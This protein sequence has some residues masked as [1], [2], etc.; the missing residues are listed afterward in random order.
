MIKLYDRDKIKDVRSNLKSIG[1]RL[2]S[3]TFLYSQNIDSFL[4]GV[5]ATGDLIID[6]YYSNVEAELLVVGEEICKIKKITT[7]SVNRLTQIEV[8]RGY[9]GTPVTNLLQGALVSSVI[10]VTL[11]VTRCE[12]NEIMDY[13]SN[14]FLVAYGTGT[15]VLNHKLSDWSRISK[16]KKY[17]W[18][19]YKSKVFFFEGYEDQV[20]LT[21]TGFVKRYNSS[22]TTSGLGESV[23]FNL[24]DK[25]GSY[26]DK[27]LKRIDPM[28]NVTVDEAL[29]KIFEIPMEKIYYRHID[30]DKYPIIPVIIPNTY[31]QYSEIVQ[32]FSTNGIRFYF[33]PQGH[34]IIFS[35]VV[36]NTNLTANSYLDDVIHL[37]DIG[38]TSDN[39]LIYNYFDVTYGEK[40]PLFGLDHGVNYKYKVNG[41]VGTILQ[42]N[43]NGDYYVKEIT[44]ND[45]TIPPRIPNLKD[46]VLMIKDNITGLEF[47]CKLVDVNASG[48][49]II[50]MALFVQRGLLEFGRGQWLESLGFLNDRTFTLYYSQEVLPIVS[51]LSNSEDTTA[52]VTS[53]SNTIPIVPQIVDSDNTTELFNLNKIYELNFGSGVPLKNLEYTGDFVG[54]NNLKGEWIGGSDL[55]YCR[56]WEQSQKGLDIFVT[57]TRSDNRDLTKYQPYYTHQDNSGFKL[58]VYESLKDNNIKA[59][60]FNTVRDKIKIDDIDKVSFETS[61]IVAYSWIKPKLGL[62]PNDVLFAYKLLDGATAQEKAK[63]KEAQSANIKIRIASMT[64]TQGQQMLACNNL[65]FPHIEYGILRLEDIVYIQEMYIRLDPIVQSSEQI[66][67]EN[68]SSVELYDGKK[69]FSLVN[70][71]FDKD[72]T[73]KLISFVNSG[74]SGLDKESMKYIV[75]AQ[76]IQNLELE[77]YDLVT[78]R[79]DTVTDIDQSMLW[80]VVGKTISWQAGRTIKYNLLNIYTREIEYIDVAISEVQDFNPDEEPTYMWDGVEADKENVEELESS[81]N[82]LD[83]RWGTL[84]G[85]LIEPS[86]FSFK[87]ISGFPAL[88]IQPSGSNYQAYLDEFFLELFKNKIIVKI[89]SEFL[90]CSGS[91]AT[92]NGE[93][94]YILQIIDRSLGQSKQESSFL[95]RTA[96]VYIISEG[97]SKDFGLYSSSIYIGNGTSSG[98]LSFH[99]IGGLNIMAKT[100]KLT[101]GESLATQNFVNNEINTSTS[102]IQAD[103]NTKFEMTEEK[104]QLVAG[105]VTTTENDITVMQSNI[106]QEFDTIRFEISQIELD[107]E[108]L[109]KETEIISKIN[110]NTER[111][112]IQGKNIQLTGATSVS[113]MLNVYGTNGITVFDKNSDALSNKKTVIQ[114]GQIIFYERSP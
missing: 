80:L 86:E 70:T 109:V 30:A 66:V 95:E 22:L 76:V 104:I 16:T 85:T 110:L 4:K 8:E 99:P 77:L 92:I 103:Y 57:T 69:E 114:G 74:Y 35:E 44:V 108:G 40:S 90:Y 54:V 58:K 67:Y 25:L 32:L 37:R 1:L 96:Y 13:N 71:L 42:K 53:T 21:W 29:S 51:T 18:E 102:G 28:E 46:P 56:E 65:V 78:L 107:T 94:V 63:F 2:I 73:R 3:N 52:G 43:S 93:T 27:D 55:L 14:P 7:D 6:G 39:Q 81:V 101:T 36:D 72:Y 98:Y 33:N 24:V 68:T 105:R 50:P 48:V 9:Y 34:L 20:V 61:E 100:I 17:N 60:F 59:Q 82:I 113:G 75:P 26:W 112:Q 87:T 79:D 89:G 5:T 47:L 19:N 11:D 91:R 88:T 84:R 10:D 31:K 38:L 12:Y 23:Y 15:I 45:I 111:I 41:V 106:V 62:K 83:S 49:T 97:S 64:D